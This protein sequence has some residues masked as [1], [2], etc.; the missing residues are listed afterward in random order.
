MRKVNPQGLPEGV[1]IVRRVVNF[2]HDAPFIEPHYRKLTGF[3]STETVISFFL[4]AKI[5]VFTDSENDVSMAD[6]LVHL[7][8]I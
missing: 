4:F 6:A 5:K 3:T 1:L 7:I 8:K 2:T